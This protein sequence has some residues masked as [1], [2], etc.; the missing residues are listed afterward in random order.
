M[1]VASTVT[2]TKDFNVIFVP[3]RLKFGAEED[4]R[5]PFINYNFP[6]YGG[7]C[8]S[9]NVVNVDRRPPRRTER[10]EVDFFRHRYLC[11]DQYCGELKDTTRFSVWGVG[12]SGVRLSERFD[13]ETIR[14]IYHLLY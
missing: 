11:F 7:D 12:G 8:G 4:L 5:I 13:L 3:F 2:H 1:S 14:S 9:V 6:L 10:K